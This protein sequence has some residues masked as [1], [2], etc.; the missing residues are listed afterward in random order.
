VPGVAECQ[1][2]LL[3]CGRIT[4]LKE[5][6]RRQQ[7]DLLKRICGT[8]QNRCVSRMQQYTELRYELDIKQTTRAVFTI[9]TALAGIV[10]IRTDAFAH[11]NDIFL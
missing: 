2:G 5:T 4:R 3:H 10:F 7:F 6:N 9:S 11:R 1:P 8:E